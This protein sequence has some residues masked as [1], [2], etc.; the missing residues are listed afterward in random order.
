MWQSVTMMILRWLFRF[1]FLVWSPIVICDGGA[2]PDVV[3][4]VVMFAPGGRSKLIDE[5]APVGGDLPYP[6]IAFQS[7]LQAKQAVEKLFVP[8]DPRREGGRANGAVAHTAHIRPPRIPLLH[9]GEEIDGRRILGAQE[10]FSF[11]G[12]PAPNGDQILHRLEVGRVIGELHLLPLIPMPH[13]HRDRPFLNIFPT[14]YRTPP[15]LQLTQRPSVRSHDVGN[16]LRS[17]PIV[18][19]MRHVASLHQLP[20]HH[21]CVVHQKPYPEVEQILPQHLLE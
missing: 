10:D 7:Q 14:K 12:G 2:A 18:I 3:V 4:E 19:V 1:T 13:M 17:P 11:Q 16:A 20:E 5:T 6:R 9:F 15:P 8:S 21:R